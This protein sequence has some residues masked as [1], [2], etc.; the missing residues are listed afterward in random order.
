VSFLNSL[1]LENDRVLGELLLS[2]ERTAGH[3]WI[4]GLVDIHGIH[5]A[6][7]TAQFI[8]QATAALCSEESRFYGSRQLV[9]SVELA[10]LYL[11]RA[12][13]TDGTI[14]LHTTNFHAP[15]AA[16]FAVEPLAAAVSLL[17]Q[18]SPEVEGFPV[19]EL[20]TFLRRAGQALIVGGIHTP[21]HRWVVCAALAQLNSLFPDDR[22]IARIDEWLAEGIDID[23]D[24]QYTERSTSIY[25]ATCDRMLITVARLLGRP[26][27]FEPV[28]RN[29]EMTRFLVHPN[30][31]VVT[32]IS[33]RQDQ[34]KAGSL[35]RYYLPYL[36]MALRDQNGDFAAMA[37]LIEEKFGVALSSELL[38]LLE[39][40]EYRMVPP[41]SLTL[42]DTYIR[43]FPASGLL[44]IREGSISASV[45][46]DNSTF[47]GMHQGNAVL[48]GL[49]FAS[50]FFGKGQFRGSLT[51]EGRK[52]ELVQNLRAPY[53]QPL[54]PGVIPYGTWPQGNRMLREQTE[55]QELTSRV[56]VDF[57]ERQFGCRIEIDGTERV[58][59]SVELS[60]RKGG[61][62]V[63]VEPIEDTP[64]AYCLTGDFGEYRIGSDRIRF[65]PG[66]T[67]HRW[68]QLRGAE[69]KL[70]GLSV[71]LT[72]FTPFEQ[73]IQIVGCSG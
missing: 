43:Y 64:N 23:A 18:T 72:G 4:G 63:G 57:G 42:P 20:E 58:P 1:V 62:L 27:L 7:G 5:L 70:D 44:R 13:H 56:R 37:G 47:F 35:R 26:G 49:R 8:G 29:L 34:Y 10:I 28:R 38:H 17:R 51:F 45:F 40:P 14:D 12:Q 21:N 67:E 16:A 65:G 31:E 50:A 59:V 46:S 60:F 6:R 3:P 55:V 9:E 68:I 39:N 53:Y 25:S 41:P 71:Y 19:E 54:P 52:C 2:Q 15:P 73:T 61:T 24:G 66:R 32:E 33:R 48:Q 22:Y 36:Y 11:L 69:P 30:G